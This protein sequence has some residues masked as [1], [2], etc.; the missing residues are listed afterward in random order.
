MTMLQTVDS[1][2]SLS[3]PP[4]VGWRG[5]LL[6]FAR[7]STGFLERLHSEHGKIVRVG[8]GKLSAT[9]TF[10]PEYTRRILSDPEFFY[11]FSLDDVPFPFSD[12]QVLKSMTTAIALLNGEQHKRHRRLMAPAFHSSVL[13]V[14][15]DQIIE[16]VEKYFNKWT[17]GQMI[18]LQREM[19]LFTN[20]LAM[21][22]FVGM[23]SDE[24]S[25]H[26]AHLFETVLELLFKP[27]TFLLP[28]DLPG[29][30]YHRLRVKGTELERQL[31][32]L[33]R[34]RSEK[35]LG[36]MDLVSMFLQAQDEDGSRMSENEI[37]G[38]TVAVFRGGSKT[39]ASTMTWTLFLLTQHPDIYSALTD[40]LSGTLRGASPTM[41][42]L[43]R[44]P[45][46]EGVIK[47]SMRL[48]PP[49]LWGIRY[50][51]DDFE[52]GGYQHETGS[53]VIYSSYVTHHM[54]ELYND[55]QKF[56]PYRWETIR[57]S[58]YEYLPFNAGPRRCLGAEFA[59]MEMKI[60]LAILLQ[61]YHFT[62]LPNQRIDRV[63]MTGS[64]PKHGIRMKIERPGA[65]FTKVAVK[66]NVHR[67]VDLT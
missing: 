63:G 58:A 44:L 14:Y 49:V 8:Q 27:S 67:L 11:S 30:S 2:P 7:D 65:R 32:D 1:I 43:S 42:Q 29:F 47:E 16:L 34:R 57:P 21:K 26:F 56:N 20:L 23:E 25:R 40:E 17:P 10:H 33:I 36:G 4:F 24:E 15:V 62:L 46:L 13:P 38:E 5:T 51:V 12:I 19:D 48:V 60:V 39:S 64:L 31:R 6:D 41:E 45:L 3:F 22:I 35:G 37:I 53:S 9:F 50:S 18:D 28:Y 61:R 59:M 54:P 55:P 66:G 52:L